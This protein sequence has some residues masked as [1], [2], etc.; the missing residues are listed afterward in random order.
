[1][2]WQQLKKAQR[3]CP[4]LNKLISGSSPCLLLS[5]KHGTASSPP[6]L[7]LGACEGCFIGSQDNPPPFLAAFVTRTGT[8]TSATGNL[9]GA[10]DCT[11]ALSEIGSTETPVSPCPEDASHGVPQEPAHHR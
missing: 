10:A 4:K 1:M 2:E 3:S 8:E 7:Q 6:A 9:S 5:R 11:S